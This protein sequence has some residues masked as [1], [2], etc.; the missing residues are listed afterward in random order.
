LAAGINGYRRSHNT[1]LTGKF[2]SPAFSVTRKHSFGIIRRSASPAEAIPQIQS[3]IAQ[4]DAAKS[5]K[6]LDLFRYGESAGLA[7]RSSEWCGSGE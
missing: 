7:R 5:R 3:E 1:I 4:L 2:F 6:P